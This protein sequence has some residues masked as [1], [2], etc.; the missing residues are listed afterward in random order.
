MA[1]TSSPPRE[2]PSSGVP[3]IRQRH[4]LCQVFPANGAL[5]V[6]LFTNLDFPSLLSFVFCTFSLVSFGASLT[7]NLP[8]LI[9]ETQRSIEVIAWVWRINVF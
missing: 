1:P 6:V 9:V 3:S 2:D 8:L 5:G 7:K 4:K